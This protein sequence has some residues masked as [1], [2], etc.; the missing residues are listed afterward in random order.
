MKQT[1]KKKTYMNTKIKHRNT[2]ANT[3]DTNY[4]QLQ[5]LY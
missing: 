4:A 5:Q 1:E 3:T 2:K